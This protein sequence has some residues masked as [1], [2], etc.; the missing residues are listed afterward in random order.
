M[1]RYRTVLSFSSFLGV[2]RDAISNWRARVTHNSITAQEPVLRHLH[3]SNFVMSYRIGPVWAGAVLFSIGKLLNNLSRE[4]FL[5]TFDV[6]H[7][8]YCY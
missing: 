1:H 3:K 4:V 7:T 6:R 8:L 5:L 2:L